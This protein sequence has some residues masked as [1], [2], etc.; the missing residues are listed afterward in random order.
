MIRRLRFPSAVP[1]DPAIDAWFDTRP[2]PLAALARP[3]Y[4][5]M[6]ACGPDVRELLH[7]GA[8]TACT[9]DVAFAYVNTFTAH[10]NVGFFVGPE[11]PDPAG[12]LEGMGKFMRHV[13]LRP[14]IGVD[15]EALGALIT[16]AYRILGAE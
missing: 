16:A 10:V 11:L 9:G 3:W 4:E 8:P 15:P 2:A 5:R 12:I 13:K 14:G 6:R 1:R 7:D